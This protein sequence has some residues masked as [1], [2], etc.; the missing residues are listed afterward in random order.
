MKQ[1]CVNTWRCSSEDRARWSSRVPALAAEDMSGAPNGAPPH[2][3][4][5]ARTARPQ[6][7]DNSMRLTP[8]LL[9]EVQKVLAA[10]DLD[11]WLLY[12]FRGTNPIASAMLG[13]EGLVSRRVF[14]FIPRSGAPIAVTHAIEQGPWKDWPRDWKKVVYS[15]WRGLEQ[16]VAAVV[17]G[18]RVAMEY[19]AGDAIP[20]LDRIPA[21]VLELV[22]ASG[23]K[24]V[25]T[26]ADLV[27]RFFAGWTADGL[28]SHTR[29]AEA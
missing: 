2:R 4:N 15:G 29:A 8:A 23:A 3:P 16:E 9:P 17:K 13:L 28:A 6:P 10:A 14:A 19:A 21:G 18:K 1:R 26:S 11:G 12:D 5:G 24:D 25:V 7:A 22:R 20:Y 27:T